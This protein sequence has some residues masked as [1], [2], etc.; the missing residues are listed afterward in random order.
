MALSFLSLNHPEQQEGRRRHYAQCMAALIRSSDGGGR[1]S[2]FAQALNNALAAI[3][4]FEAPDK[5]YRT[6]SRVHSATDLLKTLQTMGVQQA[7]GV[8]LVADSEHDATLQAHL[9]EVLGTDNDAMEGVVAVDVPRLT[10][11][12]AATDAPRHAREGDVLEDAAIL[13]LREL[14]RHPALR[15]LDDEVHDVAEVEAISADAA[16]RE[17]AGRYWAAL[18]EG[19]R[20]RRHLALAIHEGYG[21]SAYLAEAAECPVCG[22]LTLEIETVSD[23]FG[24]GFGPGCCL[25]CSY[26][27]SEDA[28]DW[29]A[30]DVKLGWGY[31]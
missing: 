12:I 18:P 3:V 1:E 17:R 9:D 29:L 24:L 10:E 4:C 6:D 19:E 20:T 13:A 14:D 22:G 27:R 26:R 21:D 8:V 16:E 5:L 15:V 31:A 30:I 7:D 23:A 11:A 28:A 25:A 2:V